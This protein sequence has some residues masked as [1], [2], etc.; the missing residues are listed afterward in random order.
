MFYYLL[1]GASEEEKKKHMLLEPK[2]YHY[3]NEEV[4]IEETPSEKYEF[5]RLKTSMESVGFGP[6]IQQK[7]FGIISSVLLLGNVQYIKVHMLFKCIKIVVGKIKQFTLYNFS[8]IQ[9][10]SN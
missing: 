8:C 10:K 5:E 4:L 1:I 9:Q 7:M 2:D 3:L 6:I